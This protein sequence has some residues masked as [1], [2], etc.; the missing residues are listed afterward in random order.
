VRASAAREY[1]SAMAREHD[2]SRRRLVEI[3]RLAY[4]G[5]LAAALAYHGHARSV[6]DAEERRRIEEIEADEIRHR[7]ALGEMLEQLGTRASRAR[8]VRALVVGRSLA[9]LCRVS[10]WYV[11]MY[12]AGRL[13]RGNIREY[14]R[15]ARYA[16]D[17][18]EARWIECLLEMA[19]V[20]WEH[21]RFFRERV[22]TRA[23]AAPLLARWLRPWSS[24]PP[25]AS[26]REAF[27]RETV[28]TTRPEA[29]PA[30]S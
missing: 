2:A 14:E 15:A 9:L 28:A 19:E 1:D 11:P 16:R 8:E 25:K 10:G 20:E 12:G 7:A 23:R 3:L 30:L 13:E 24:T 4:S 26:I 27:A 22:E 5:E 17:S 29:L 21:E 6:R 18:G